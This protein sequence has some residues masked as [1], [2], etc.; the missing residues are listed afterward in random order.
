MEQDNL[1]LKNELMHEREETKKAS[2]ANKWKMT[3][4]KEKKFR[5]QIKKDEVLKE[6][7]TDTLPDEG[8]TRSIVDY[9]VR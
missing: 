9:I 5:Q 7:E 2:I 6:L 8:T 4:L 1:K 3:I